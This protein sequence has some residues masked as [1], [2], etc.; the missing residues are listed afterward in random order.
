LEMQLRLLHP[1]MP[2]ITEELWQRL[3]GRG[4]LGEDE[5]PTIMLAKYPEF[6]A[7]YI[8]ETAE[9]SMAVILDIVKACNSLRASYNIVPKNLTHYYIKMTEGADIAT[10]QADDIATHG[11]GSQVDI[12]P[13][14]GTIPDSVGTM[15]VNDSITLYVDLKGMVDFKT[16]IGRLNKQLEKSKGPMEKLEIKMSA[17]GYQENVSDELKQEN[18]E[19]LEG[20][21]KKVSGIE[22]AIANFKRMLSFEDK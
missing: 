6:N 4:T 18:I 3:P 10:A 5:T 2:F 9:Q 14:E 7:N 12:N 8:D 17:D 19:K 13:P 20:Y 22:E 21:K 16:E 1:M 11:K 15:V